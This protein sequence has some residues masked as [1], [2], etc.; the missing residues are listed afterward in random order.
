MRANLVPNPAT[1]FGHS[2]RQIVRLVRHA[3][4][5]ALVCGMCLPVVARAD[6]LNVPGQYSTIQAAIDAAEP[7][8]EVIIADGVYTGP[9]NKNLDFGGKDITVRSA[10]GNPETCTIQCQN[11][12][13]GF[14]LHQGESNGA[15][16]EGLTVT[17]G[18]ELH[19]AG[20]V[21]ANSSP[22][23]VNCHIQYN[24]ADWDGGQM[25]PRG[26]GLFISEA[27]PRLLRCLIRGNQVYGDSEAEIMGGGGGVYVDGSNA[28]IVMHDCRIDLNRA[29]PTGEG[30]GVAL[31]FSQAEFA[32]CV[33]D[34]NICDNAGGAL[35]IG[36][37]SAALSDC[38]FFRNSALAGGA[39]AAGLGSTTLDRCGFGDNTALLYG[40]AVYSSHTA[41]TS[42]E[43]WF[44][45]NS[46]VDVNGFG[47]GGAV[48]CRDYSLPSFYGCSFF[49]NWAYAGGGSLWCDWS[50]V[51]LQA[52]V[53]NGNITFGD[54]AGGIYL[55]S[56]ATV[57]RDHSVVADC[58]F[59]GNSGRYAGALR[60]YAG[61]RDE[62]RNCV[63]IDN[64]TD[65]NG[66]AV[67]ASDTLALSNSIVRG[68]SGAVISGNAVVRFSNV[69]GGWPGEGNIDENP[70]FLRN[71]DPGPDGLWGTPDDD[72]GDLRL[73]SGS[74]CIDAGNPNFVAQPPETDLDGHLR[75]WDGTGGGLAIVDMGAYE[76]GARPCG[77]LNCDGMVDF[78]DVNPFVQYLSNTL[79]WQAAYP[80]CD[81]RVGDINGDGTYGYLSFG[82]INP[83]VVLLTGG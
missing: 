12:G 46:A 62:V 39:I 52:S 20:V 76:F 6:T 51:L 26:G 63:F 10:S 8:D 83:F 43:C 5:G 45:S 60:Q 13:R 14:Y 65:S 53:F 25:S 40:G 27:S 66:A 81:P 38:D 36:G 78:G 19:G 16:I 69:S 73:Q 35:D 23:F 64:Q 58:V 4:R 50:S 61:F 21:C 31:W 3:L 41:V 47:W 7:G 28:T 24:N 79:A 11:A 30:G 74:P 59:I 68:T 67:V 1:Q 56:V 80:A 2:D 54:W 42:N 71:P 48:Y 33:F 29:Y 49:D 55:S 18:A 70:L 37:G 44:E 32:R 22:T 15:R 57:A 17:G 82:D 72:Y 34:G 75:I 77:D 9:G